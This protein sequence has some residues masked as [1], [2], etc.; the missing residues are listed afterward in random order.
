VGVGVAFRPGEP[1]GVGVGVAVAV[2]VGLGVGLGFM[3]VG[4]FGVAVGLGLGVGAK[5]GVG[6]TVGVGVGEELCAKALRGGTAHPATIRSSRQHAAV[7]ARTLNVL[8]QK[9]RTT[10][11]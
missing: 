10:Q 1:S 9:N 11:K 2:G 4:P 7:T 3:S 5:S 6:E 8:A